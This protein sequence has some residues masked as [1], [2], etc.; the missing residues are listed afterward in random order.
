MS[1]KQWKTSENQNKIDVKVLSE[2]P[3]SLLISYFYFMYKTKFEGLVVT[4]A[5]MEDIEKWSHGVVD[6]PDTVNYRT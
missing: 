4:L 5:S 1:F 3:A 2:L 6:N